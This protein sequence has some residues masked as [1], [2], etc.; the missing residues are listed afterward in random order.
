MVLLNDIK[1]EIKFTWKQNK[2]LQRDKSS[3]LT[4]C[5]SVTK[6]EVHQT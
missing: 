6:K 3:D 1:R 4:G 5:K 2:T